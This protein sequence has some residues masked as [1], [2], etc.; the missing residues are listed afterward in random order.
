MENP[1]ISIDSISDKEV[2]GWAR[3]EIIVEDLIKQDPKMEMYIRR[4]TVDDVNQIRKTYSE[5]LPAIQEP[6]FVVNI[7]SSGMVSNQGYKKIR[8]YYNTK[9]MLIFHLETN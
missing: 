2:I 1:L 4:L 6:I 8:L 5:L 7:I 9:G 3:K